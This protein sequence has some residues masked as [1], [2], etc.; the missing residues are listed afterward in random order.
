[1]TQH[2]L[3]PESKLPLLGTTIFSQMSALAQQHNAINLSQGFP[4]FS[5]PDYLQQRLAYHVS[6]GANQYAPM[7]GALPLREAIAEKT[8]RLYDY[9]PDVETEITVTAG[10]TEALYAAITALVRA[11]R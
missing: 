6:Q 8:A 9:R 2:N 4:D 11:R 5:G 3:I 1:M 10:A 7:T